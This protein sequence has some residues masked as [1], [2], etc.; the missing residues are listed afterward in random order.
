MN[1]KSL[2]TTRDWTN[3]PAVPPATVYSSSEYS[4]PP[5]QAGSL[6]DYWGLIWHGKGLFTGFLMG[7]LV[8]ALG[9]LFTQT[10]VYR[11]RTSLEV[12][13][14][15]H[16]FVNMKL[17]GP[18]A[19]SSSTDAL[20]DI[21]TQIK[22][23]QSDT[24][25]D[26]ALVKA[27]INSPSDLNP[28]PRVSFQWAGILNPS[29]T[30]DVKETLA[31]VAG[32]K[33]K[34]GVAGQTRIVEVSF[35][36]PRP[37]LAARFANALTSEFID[38]NSQVRWRTNRQTSAWLA[39]QLDEL[40]GKLETSENALQ[41]YARRQSLIYTADKQTVSEE[42]LRQVQAEL[43]RAQA[44]RVE[45]QS[46]FEM[47]RTAKPDTLPDV[48][49]DSNLRAL[50][51]SLTDLRRQE[52]QMEVT[53]TGDYSRTKKLHAEISALEDAIAQKRSEI[54]SRITNELT[55]AQR[56]EQ[57]LTAAYAD[58]T[59]RVTN[60]SQKSI[61]YDLLKREVDTNQQIYEAMLQRVKESTIA[62]AIKASNVRVIDPALPPLHPYK[63]NWPLGSA[64]G[65]LGGGLFGLLAIV[66]RAR[67]DVS[68]QHPGEAGALLGIPELGV[69][70][71]AE[72]APRNPTVLTLAPQDGGLNGPNTRLLTS[73]NSLAVADGF[74]AVL[75]SIIFAGANEQQRVLV[76]TSANSGEGKTTAAANL[77]MTLSKM[78]RKVLLIDGDIRSP[79][80][81][82]VFGLDNSTGVTDLLNHSGPK[83]SLSEPV[84][85]AV[86]PNLYVLTAGPAVEAGANLLF[87]SAMPA[88]IA[89]YRERFDMVLIDTPPMLSMP[90][91]RVLGRISDGVVLVA[92]S[93]KTSRAAVQ[94][95]FR[96]LV[97]DHSNVLGII[98]ND[99]NVKA[100]AYKYYG[101]Y[102]YA[103]AANSNAK[104]TS[105]SL[106][107]TTEPRN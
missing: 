6:L 86:A 48:L 107:T 2:I 67:T 28:N 62:S 82:Q 9:I 30:G 72:I 68:V 98:L 47:A 42:K 37:E 53:F 21:Q 10:P 32:K 94:A 93:G 104:L 81:H 55:G 8:V 14:L 61:Q 41:A 105:R 88:L 17:T 29:G 71:R 31:E 97:D 84:I 49:N 4:A 36:A 46:R 19:D 59:V 44:D 87:S 13:D 78:Q 3:L 90:D 1:D 11:A 65:L 7:G 64:A 38:Q 45:K 18:V 75:A 83:E 69:I 54:V 51:T 91:A 99:W 22:I 39:S 20:T 77:A 35:D 85:Q 92:R 15:N 16:E 58:Q 33:L 12:Q 50:E 24:L 95:A 57:L 43:S 100:S 52:A 89:R 60:D 40:R 80:L 26:S 73:G 96:R 5:Q 34:V 56:R 103:A 70:P 74:R 63:P 23:L 101:G 27:G 106:A 25:I 66:V 76:I 79:R 102:N